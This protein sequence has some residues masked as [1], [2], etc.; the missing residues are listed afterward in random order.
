MKQVFDGVGLVEHFVM[1][2]VVTWDGDQ[3]FCTYTPKHKDCFSTLGC[4]EEINMSDVELI[5]E[6]C[7]VI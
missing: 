6:V 3:K 5:F 7:D 4:H 1:Y 2:L